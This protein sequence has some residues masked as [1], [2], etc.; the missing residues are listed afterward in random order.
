MNPNPQINGNELSHFGD[1]MQYNSISNPLII[2]KNLIQ[3]ELFN[4]IKTGK[5]YIDIFIFVFITY[6]QTN[7]EKYT[8][9]SLLK[10][11]KGFCVRM[12]LHDKAFGRYFKSKEKVLKKVTVSYI[13]ENREINT[14]YDPVLWYI[15]RLSNSKEQMDSHIE[16]TKNN[17]DL[18]QYS[19]SSS[20]EVIEFKDHK[21]E[22]KLYKDLVTIYADREYKK[23]NPAIDIS[24]LTDKNSDILREFCQTCVT[25]YEEN[26]KKQQWVQKIYRNNEKG[27]WTA[28]D[29]KQK[30]K[31][32][33][34]IL[35]ENVKENL[36][37]DLD[38]FLSTEEWYISR[39]IPY[40][41][42]YLFYGEPGTGKSSLI[43]AISNKTKRHIHYLILSTVKSDEE[44]FKLFEKVKFD[45]TILV[46]E[47]IDCMSKITHERSDEEKI[48]MQKKQSI[49][50]AMSLIANSGA[51]QSTKEGAEKDIITSL[52][53][54]E[55]KTLTL[56]GLLNA[57]DGGIID[58]HGQIMIMTTNHKNKLDKALIRPGRVDGDFH[59]GY[60]DKQQILDLYNNFFGEYPAD[61]NIHISQGITP[62]MIVQIFL[63]YK[64]QPKVAWNEVEKC[65]KII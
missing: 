12:L 45:E 18:F 44:L 15:N 11:F 57:I 23:E 42:R 41:R 9:M 30:R 26:K 51:S 8:D 37:A 55:K 58:N 24:T 28:N 31:L 62:A 63:Q 21:L 47:D 60:C 65:N 52:L 20:S 54:E 38:E 6:V 1:Y 59:F 43:K 14:M 2:A 64:T 17:K 19:K 40:T 34:V 3:Y 50:D 35:K 49:M 25:L 22:Y 36:T 7:M 46:I 4:K 27:E 5:Y 53:K 61:T 48:E 39:D 10:R 29:S 33:T 32:E 16:I 13:T 56:S